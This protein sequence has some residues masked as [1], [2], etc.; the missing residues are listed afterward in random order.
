[1]EEMYKEVAGWL[2]PLGYVEVF[3][4]HPN[5]R[6][7]QF[8]FIKDGVRLV[9]VLDRYKTIKEAVCYFSSDVFT[10]PYYVSI[11]SHKLPLFTEE[12]E[13]LSKF[14][15]EQSDKLKQN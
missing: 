10:H 9:C 7:R 14:I 13:T 4:N 11:T 3:A 6:Y 15:K 2:I 12:L 5:E 1:M 8:H